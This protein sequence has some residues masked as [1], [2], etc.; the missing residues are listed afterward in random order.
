MEAYRHDYSGEIEFDIT[1]PDG[2]ARKLMD[3]SRVERL[4]WKARINLEEGLKMTYDW[5]L[6]NY[7]EITNSRIFNNINFNNLLKQQLAC[8]NPK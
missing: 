2:T 4:G 8:K 3:T 1:K 5:F 6:S 7:E